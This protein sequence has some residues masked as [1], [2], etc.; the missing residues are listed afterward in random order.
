MVS[1]PSGPLGEV[2]C[3]ERLLPMKLFDR[4]ASK[5]VHTVLRLRWGSQELHKR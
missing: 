4:G 2:L 5:C 3:F 1:R